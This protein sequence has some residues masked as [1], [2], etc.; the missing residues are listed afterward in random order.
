M[1]F[2][3]VHSQ[4]WT[5]L[6]QWT[7]SDITWP[8]E[9][10]MH[11]KTCWKALV[12]LLWK[13][14]RLITGWRWPSVMLRVSSSDNPGVSIIHC[15]ISGSRRIRKWRNVSSR[16]GW[17]SKV[18]FLTVVVSPNV[19]IVW[20]M[21]CQGFD[22]LLQR[23]FRLC[24]VW[25]ALDKWFS[26]TLRPTQEKDL[27]RFAPICQCHSSG[28]YKAR[29]LYST[30]IHVIKLWAQLSCKG[31]GRGSSGWCQVEVGDL[32]LSIPWAGGCG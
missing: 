21:I 11:C 1:V 27:N 19:S 7:Y 22:P 23:T 17:G 15:W 2:K 25:M 6:M 16:A 18:I 24:S 26:K 20:E 28:L 30:L 12:S 10:L 3:L 29:G 9:C 4:Y 14:Q 8:H 13:K 5:W 31:S 32:W